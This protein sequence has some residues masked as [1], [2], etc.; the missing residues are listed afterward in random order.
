MQQIIKFF[1]RNKVGILFILLFVFS[2]ALTI[3]A[4]SYHKSKWLSST[5]SVSAFI[6]NTRYSITSYFDLKTANKKLHQENLYLKERLYNQKNEVIRDSVSQDSLFYIKACHVI[7]NSYRKVD[8][9]ALI[10]IGQNDA[11]YENYAVTLPDGVL[12]IVEKSNSNFA[13]VISILNTNLSINAKLKKSHHFGSLHWDGINPALMDLKDLPRSAKF[14]IGDSIVTGSN[15]LIF[16]KNI[17]IGKIVDFNLNENLGYYDIK[18]ELFADM[19]NLDQA[20][21]IIPK[22]I[23]QAKQL[24][25]SNE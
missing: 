4:H 19:T 16:P 15:S 24:M 17:P 21:V 7:S 23:T 8:N 12:G 6:L 1:I 18:V 14:Q 22:K 2:I 10:D 20:Y 11:V 25:K 9:Y 13:R 5:Q 3:Q